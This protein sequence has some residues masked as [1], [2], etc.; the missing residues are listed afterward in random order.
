MANTIESFYILFSSWLVSMSVGIRFSI[1]LLLVERVNKIHSNSFY[2]SASILA[3]RIDSIIAL[4]IGVVFFH[5]KSF[6][7]S[8]QFPLIS[9]R[10]HDCE[11]ANFKW[12][13]LRKKKTASAQTLFQFI[14]F[15]FFGFNSLQT[16]FHLLYIWLDTSKNGEKRKS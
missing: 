11:I 5:P 1:I 14:S 2:F 15:A 9:T 6:F 13:E 10:N 3:F 4:L 12:L 8:C 16:N 7:Y